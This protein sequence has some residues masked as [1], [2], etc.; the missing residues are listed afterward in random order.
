VTPNLPLLVQQLTQQ[1]VLQ[2]LIH[3]VSFLHSHVLSSTHGHVL[4]GAMVRE[5]DLLAA[6]A[7]NDHTTVQRL[8]HDGVYVNFV[9]LV[10]LRFST[11]SAS[12]A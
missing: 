6:A 1:L 12:R 8:I 3:L 9:D 5:N 10:L 4:I 2:I 7:A 11:S